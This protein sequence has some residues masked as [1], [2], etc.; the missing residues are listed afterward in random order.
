[1]AF[2]M[3][4]FSTWRISPSTHTIFLLARCCPSS[5]PIC[6]LRR[7]L[8]TLAMQAHHAC[9]NDLLRRDLQLHIA[10]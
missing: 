10:Q 3:R 6:A 1:M 8:Q 9:F 4:L 7:R 5:T 2:P